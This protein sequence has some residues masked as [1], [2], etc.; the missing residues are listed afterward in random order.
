MAQKKNIS[1]YQNLLNFINNE[2]R[3]S[4]DARKL[5]KEYNLTIQERRE[6]DTL[7]EDRVD[8][9]VIAILDNY[10]K[11]KDFKEINEILLRII[12]DYK[13]I[14]EKEKT[15]NARIDG[16]IKNIYT[17]ILGN[18]GTN[19]QGFDYSFLEE[20][21]KGKLKNANDNLINRDD[22][23]NILKE[24]AKIEFYY[25][26][27]GYQNLINNVLISY[28]DNDIKGVTNSKAIEVLIDLANSY[29][30]QGKAEES[31]D[32]YLKGL[33]LYNQMGCNN[34]ELKK[35][36]EQGA[37]VEGDISE[38]LK[39]VI[40][41]VEV[42]SEQSLT[43]KFL[44]IDADS[45]DSLVQ[46]LKG[47]KIPTIDTHKTIPGE[48][49]KRKPKEPDDPNKI[50]KEKNNYIM[51]VSEKHEGIKLALKKL[52]LTIETIKKFKELSPEN[53]N[54]LLRALQDK[55]E[56]YQDYV[57]IGI[58]EGNLS[59]L[60]CYS[61]TQKHLQIIQNENVSEILQF[62]K[63][64]D[65]KLGGSIPKKHTAGTF[66]QNLTE[67]LEQC[68]EKRKLGL[69]ITDKLSRRKRKSEPRNI[70]PE[71]KII[72]SEE[73]QNNYDN[74]SLEELKE[75]AEYIKEQIRLKTNELIENMADK[76]IRKQK[77]QELKE[78]YNR[79]EEV[80]SELENMK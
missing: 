6:N 52:G 19:S 7:N 39:K 62:E 71:E 28:L 26:F 51:P 47:E 73:K 55:I 3:S 17:E 29:R 37:E 77:S 72:K 43:D 25:D 74:S 32:I 27:E 18:P 10:D 54:E 45:V 35:E 64:R 48:P 79:L 60:E 53:D 20:I 57:L 22:V 23:L 76:E 70:E 78:L 42:E 9:I 14:K 46:G 24:Q 44:S 33:E 59:L 65:Q 4:K 80:Q 8:R 21:I 12:E 66:A 68:I 36:L 15:D 49:I 61:T 2:E 30:I 67:E 34:E 13:Y 69:K 41:N 75:E 31:K 1:L 56:D 16:V 63:L 11:L 50:K 40:D 5:K 58:K 38:K